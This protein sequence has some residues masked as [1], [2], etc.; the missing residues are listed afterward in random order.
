MTLQRATGDP[1]VHARTHAHMPEQPISLDGAYVVSPGA[2]D[3]NA[4]GGNPVG[5]VVAISG[6]RA[7]LASVRD[8]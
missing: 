3:A 6:P 8:P 5:E 7:T 2:P 1:H 4:E